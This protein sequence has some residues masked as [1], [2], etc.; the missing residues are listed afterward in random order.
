MET[1]HVVTCF[2]RHGT[3]VLFV[4][5]SDVVGTYAGRWGGVSGYA[6]G[7]PDE[8]ARW[9]INEEVGLLSAAT[10]VRRGEP[11]T[12]DDDERG[13]RWV[14]HPYLFA[15]EHRDVTPNEDVAAVEW[16]QPPV[17]RDRETVPKLWAAYR[18]VGPAAE[19]VREDTDHG[20]A[21]ISLRALEALRDRAAEADDYAAVAETGQALL[22]AQ[23]SMAVVRNRISRVLSAAG[24]TPTAVCQ[25]AM[26][27]CKAALE[28][29][30]EAA[31]RAA[32]SLGERV[33]TLSRSGTVE[34]AV[35]EAEPSRVVVA[36]SRPGREGVGT[37]ERLAE[38]GIDV[39][40]CADAAVTAALSTADIET[41]VFGADTVLADG[42]VINKV[43]SHPAALAAA[44]ADIECLAVC[45]RDKMSPTTAANIETGPP[46]A[47]Y[48]GDADVSV[49]NPTFECVPA[50]LVDGI[51]TEAGRLPTTDV[52]A[53]A[54][55]HADNRDW[56]P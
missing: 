11:V 35:S 52:A 46:E 30:A 13:R 25:A 1:E 12:V 44:E 45:S 6:E 7:T 22:D 14:V 51:V 38:A 31:S 39:T 23:P 29:D 54:A 4:E 5:R 8:A 43:G 28:A 49:Y 41:V 2:L 33:L 15:V 36:E 37:A 16:L 24:R 21:A 48:D 47:V 10:L 9:G 34:A 40:V 20:A 32:D 27:A 26:D 18:A 42:S 56:R 17:I 19:T 55:R 53:I 3:E 50:S